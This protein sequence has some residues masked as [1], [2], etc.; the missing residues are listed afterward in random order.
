MADHGKT[1]R[2]DYINLE[3]ADN[4]YILRFTI[5]KDSEESGHYDDCN[6]IDK[7]LVY[8]EDQDEEAFA[9]FKQI[10]M[11][12]KAMKM[13]EAADMPEMPTASSSHNPMRVMG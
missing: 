12:N 3:P 13:G 4:G 7:K 1:K 8:T 11:F 2:F 9:K 6:H 5:V 10:H